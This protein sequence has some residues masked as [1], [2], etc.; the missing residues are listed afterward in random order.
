LGFTGDIYDGLVL[1]DSLNR[2]Q[3]PATAYPFTIG[4]E[5][6]SVDGRD[7]NSL[8]DEYLKYVAYANPKA[9]RRVAAA[10]IT[11][12]PQSRM[13]H[14]TD[15]LNR[16]VAQVVIHRQNGALETYN[17]PWAV[18]GTP[19]EVG[20]VPTPKAPRAA[21]PQPASAEPDYMQPLIAAQWSGVEPE[22]GLNGYGARNPIFINGLSSFQFTRRL[23]GSSADFYYSGVFKF[24]ELNIGY[25]RI[26]NY[27]PPSTSV[28]LTQF[29]Q[30]MAY[31]NLNTDGLIVDE[32]RNTGGNLCFGE[33]IMARLTP[34]SFQ[35]TGFAL[36][37]FWSRVLGFYNAWN[38]AK[39]NGAPKQIVDQYE[40]LYK[41]ML[42]ANQKGRLITDPLPLCTSSLTRTALADKNGNLIAYLRPVA[43]LIDEFST[44]TADSVPGMFQDVRR[45]WL[46]G[47]RTDGAG[48]NNTTFDAGSYSE[49]TTGMTLALQ[50]RQY[51]VSNAFSGYPYTEYIEN[52]GVWPDVPIEYMTKDN[53]LQNGVPFLT[54]VLQ[55]LAYEIRK[56]R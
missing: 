23:G 55:H 29:E 17:I 10:R 22:N 21:A 13:P 9:A 56:I 42:D 41:A 35:A 43:M 11:T 36:R 25:I 4:D 8:I 15:V 6:V 46:Y 1:I 2:T 32:M 20:P 44:S 34:Y 16:K 37:P 28:A 38:S 54:S 12:R 39:N 30:E 40:L 31:M 33:E 19:L 45:G 14:A 47:T 3:L 26:P 50:T 53:L 49:G 51:K 52:V 24:N 48:G 5:L 18:S 27:S 7:V